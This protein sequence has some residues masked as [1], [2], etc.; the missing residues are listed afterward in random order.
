MEITIDG[1]SIKCLTAHLHNNSL[2][3]QNCSK[4]L[5]Q[6]WIFGFV[7]QTAFESFDQIFG[8]SSIL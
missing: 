4:E 8:Y 7:N 3:L 6:K 5:N 1:G 2:G